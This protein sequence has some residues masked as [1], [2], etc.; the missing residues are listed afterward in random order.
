MH[1]NR[2]RGINMKKAVKYLILFM[3]TLV[4]LTPLTGN[5]KAQADTVSETDIS[6]IKSEGVS[7]TLDG[8][9]VS[10]IVPNAFD[11]KR[12]EFTKYK[13]LLP[14]VGYGSKSYVNIPVNV[15]ERGY[16]AFEMNGI[17]INDMVYAT[18]SANTDLSAT[19]NKE[20]DGF[21][22]IGN[23][24]SSDYYERSRGSYLYEP[25]VYYVSFYVSGSDMNQE[26]TF[27]LTF[28]TAD[29][30]V[31]K[32]GEFATGAGMSG[33]AVNYKVDVK[34]EGIIKLDYIGCDK[35][36][37]FSNSYGNFTLLNSKKKP[38]GEKKT[39]SDKTTLTWEVKSGTY[40][41]RANVKDAVYSLR[42]TW[43]AYLPAPTINKAVNR[44]M[45]VTGKA[46]KGS[47]VLV[48]VKTTFSKYNFTGKANS[49]GTYNVDVDELNKGDIVTVSL[50]NAKGQI[51][52][53]KTIKV[54]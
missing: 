33:T 41:I 5:L 49:K 32:D 8:Q 43:L 18:I 10:S 34:K 1:N 44:D 29:N 25:G 6:I 28:T 45:T 7:V 39:V 54:K 20:V 46:L 14:K 38:V 15:E 26:F 3:L 12:T 24:L 42:K 11:G 4:V 36:Y 31:L 16:L 48:N 47:K 52:K 30:K 22:S 27:D 35:D 17:N 21:F 40:Y 13:V 2:E 23:F 51:S 37:G 19:G 9:E 53:T 50:S